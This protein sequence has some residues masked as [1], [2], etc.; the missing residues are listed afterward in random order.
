MN[1]QSS[2][3]FVVASGLALPGEPDDPAGEPPGQVE[4][5]EL[6]DVA[7]E[8]A[9]LHD[10][11]G[12][13]RPAEGRL[14]LDQLV[15]PVPAQDERLGRLDRDGRRR[16]GR[17]VEEGELAEEVAA[18]QGGDDRALLALGRRQDDLHRAR[19]DDVQRVAR[20]ALVEDRLVLP[21]APDPE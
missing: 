20:V 18:R 12:E 15:E 8:P 9:Q 7:G 11:A 3:M 16:V 6:L 2:R 17:T 4:E 19:L 5:V 1:G 13:Q 21:V 10:E 14:G